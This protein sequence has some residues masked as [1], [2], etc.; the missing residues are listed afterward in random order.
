MCRHV[1]RRPPTGGNPGREGPSVKQLARSGVGILCD[2][3]SQN[4]QLE[5][6]AL[7]VYSS[8][9]EIKQQ[10]T[11]DH[12]C[13]KSS[14]YHLDTYDKSNVVNAIRGLTTMNLEEWAQEGPI[15]VILITDG[16]LYNT[17]VLKDDKPDMKQDVDYEFRDIPLK[18]LEGSFNFDCKIQIVCLTSPRD[19]ALNLSL[20]F[21]KKLVNLVDN[22]TTG[23]CP[24]LTTSSNMRN[25][26]RSAIWLPESSTSEISKEEVESL[27]TN[28]AELNYKPH[29]VTLSCGHLSSVVMLS[30]RPS[31]RLVEPLK[32][33]FDDLKNE[34]S[35]TDKKENKNFFV[36]ALNKS[37][38]FELADEID[39]CGFMALS[40]IASPA[41][42]SRHI[43]F[44]IPNSKI[45]EIE[46]AEQILLQDPNA[47][48]KSLQACA[49]D[50]EIGPNPDNRDDEKAV[51]S[52]LAIGSHQSSNDHSVE[53]DITKR[54]SFCVLL[55]NCLKQ[56]NMVAICIVG[57]N[58]ETNEEWFGTLHAHTDN[59]KKACLMLSLLT[60]GTSPI[61]WLPDF[62]TLGSA[63]LNADLP[64]A[65]L[66][67][68]TTGGGACGSGPGG[69]SYSTNNVIWLD[70]ESVQADVQKIVR[71]AKRTPDKAPHFYK[72]LNRIRRAAISYGFYDVLYGLAFILEREKSIML[73]EQ[74]KPPNPEILKHI[75]HVISCLRVRLTDDSY[76]TNILPPPG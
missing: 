74:S 76:E 72:E 33:E 60:P 75:D 71:H 61:L 35:Q 26:R 40:D 58:N 65:I 64:P 27:F 2:H 56:E 9:Y 55:H 5:H 32:N 53:R 20:P 57:K 67:R 24:V 46:K 7:V 48:N 30:P 29:N 68:L 18:E 36:S 63:T 47:Y 54:P 41:T 25:L 4:S 50:Q 10:F 12:E 49:P 19:P 3:L 43:I 11:R 14:T 13:I 38:L 22:R 17:D 51:H 31:D 45:N 21:F 42:I 73:S 39:I 1:T 52:K 66:E 70:P 15:H 28:I 59:R 62:K 8:L 44:P 34:E 69:K 37:A 23:D 6:V 16:Q